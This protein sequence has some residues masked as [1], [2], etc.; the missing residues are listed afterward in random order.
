ME[1]EIIRHYLFW[2]TFLFGCIAIIL[3]MVLSFISTDVSSDV[4]CVDSGI[5]VIDKNNYGLSSI[6]DLV[7]VIVEY[8]AQK[9]WKTERLKR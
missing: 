2:L 8:Q 6:I 3:W 7:Y 5:V 9:T 4:F 1:P